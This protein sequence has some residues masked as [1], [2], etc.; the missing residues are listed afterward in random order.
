[1]E[2]NLDA[3]RAA[4][5]DAGR[6]RR[7]ERDRG[8]LHGIP[9]DARLRFPCGQLARALVTVFGEPAHARRRGRVRNLE[10]VA[11]HAVRREHPAEPGGGGG[12][13]L[14][15]GRRHLRAVAAGPVDRRAERPRFRASRTARSRRRRPVRPSVSSPIVNPAP[16]RE[17]S[18]HQPSRT[19]RLRAPFIAAFMPDVP[20]ASN[21]RIGLFSQ[22]SAPETRRRASRMS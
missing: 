1:M 7:V 2:L 9:G 14:D 18:S 15:P 17:A 5:R 8:E 21:G 4:R 20:E 10:I 16:S 3:E 19:D 22:T 11:E 13:A 6:I 12:H